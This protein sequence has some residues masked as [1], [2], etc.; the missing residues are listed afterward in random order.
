MLKK[1]QHGVRFDT[2]HGSQD[3][4]RASVS[5]KVEDAPEEYQPLVECAAELSVRPPLFVT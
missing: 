4:L 2:S 3:L 1:E 5:W